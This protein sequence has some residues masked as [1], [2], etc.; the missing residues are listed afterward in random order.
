MSHNR[1]TFEDEDEEEDLDPMKKYM[2][3]KSKLVDEEIIES[4]N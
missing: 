3:I 4:L 1:I 2:E